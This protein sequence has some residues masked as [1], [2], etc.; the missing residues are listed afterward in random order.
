MERFEIVLCLDDEQ[1][2][3]PSMLPQER[4]NLQEILEPLF[5]SSVETTIVDSTNSK[6]NN[7]AASQYLSRNYHMSYVP[8]GFWSRLI[9]VFCKQIFF[10]PG[11]I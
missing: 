5:N 10:N 7:S 9:G 1:F 11:D 6:T 8:A 4:P 2:L 3:I